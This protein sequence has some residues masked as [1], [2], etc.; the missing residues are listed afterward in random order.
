M[1]ESAHEFS[2]ES[3]MMSAGH[4]PAQV[5]NSIKNPIFQTST[6]VFETAEEGKPFLKRYMAGPIQMRKT[7][8]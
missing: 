6:F 2:P 8:A 4:D 3:L 1:S 5:R 7:T